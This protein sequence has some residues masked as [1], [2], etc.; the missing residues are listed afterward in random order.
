MADTIITVKLTGS[1]TDGGTIELR[2]LVQF[3]ERLQKAVDRMAYSIE[4]KT[5]SRRKLSEVRQDTSL[6][7]IETKEGSFVTELNFIRPPVL[8]E[9]YYDIAT[10]AT[11]QLISG[12]EFLRNSEN[13]TLPE[14]YD[15]GVLVVLEDLGK[16]LNQGIDSMEFDVKTQKEHV[17][18]T[19]DG[20]THSRIVESISE[21]EEKIAA[22][23]GNLLMA[24]FRKDRY[25]CHLFIDDDNFISCTFDEDVADDI[26]SAMRHTV[27]AVG[28]ATINPVNDEISQFHI[29]QLTIL[30]DE[31][32][33]PQQ[34]T[35]ILD[36]YIEANDT[37]A[38]FRR[39]WA[40][41]LAGEVRP[42]SEL[43]DGIDAE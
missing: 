7:L 13:G 24:N 38:S 17:S 3:G 5:G 8:F 6:R 11:T 30:D 42:I 28:I 9:D 23:T 37:V 39:S 4:K 34:L 22:V 20:Y 14:G 2:R 15:Q 26:D 41:T 1:A 35:D 12:L 27:N 25:R 33:S 16:I 18:G 10:L 32:I 19:Y 40:E 36:N 21:P 43:W 29:K 31:K